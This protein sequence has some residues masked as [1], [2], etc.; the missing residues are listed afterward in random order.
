MKPEEMG[1]K[2]GG[3][4]MVRST[5]QLVE[6]CGD[7]V[8]PVPPSPTDVAVIMYTSG[9]TGNSK[10]VMITHQNI[11]A[12]SESTTKI[13][14]FIN[15]SSIY[16]GYLPLAHIMELFIECSLLSLGAS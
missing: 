16:L 14:P 6:G 2:M 11:V 12:Q 13:M 5:D 9:T 10:G 8:E 3:G 1:E 4:V 15:T 7:M